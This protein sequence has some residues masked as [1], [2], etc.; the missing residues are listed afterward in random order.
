[1][2]EIITD[3]VQSYKAPR[4]DAGLVVGLV[5]NG[6]YSTYGFGKISESNPIPPDGDTIFDISSITKVFTTTLLSILTTEG[7]VSLDDPVRDLLP[8]LSNLPSEMTLQQLATHSSRLPTMPDDIRPLMRKNRS[9]PFSTYTTEQLFNYLSNYEPKQQKSI[10]RYSN[11]GVALLG[12]ALAKNL[13]T[14]YEQ[15][16]IAKLCDRLGLPDTRINLTEEQNKRLA[17]PHLPSGKATQHWELPAFE[18]AGAL[19]STTNDLLKFLSAHMGEDQ[20]LP[21]E[22]IQICHQIYPGV[23]SPPLGKLHGLVSVFSKNRDISPY[24]QD[25]GLGWEVGHL[26]G[27]GK[28]VYWRH[29]GAGGFQGFIGFVKDTATGVVVLSNIGL[30]MSDLFLY[31]T[32]TDQIGFRILGYLNS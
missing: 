25:R 8:E 18:G 14:S 11:I 16:L 13:G 32:H 3:I 19:R 2:K 6:I 12:H 23:F 31:M 15:A 27:N 10:I 29:G 17:P 1:M 24:L 21:S 26:P 4:K 7:Q 30:S 20:G 5:N 9:N 22:V 28:R